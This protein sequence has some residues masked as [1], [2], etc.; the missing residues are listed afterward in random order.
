MNLRPILFSI[1]AIVVQNAFC[2]V[3]LRYGNSLD[4]GWG[5]ANTVVTP[6]VMFPE[7]FVKPY[8]G[9]RVTKVLLGL[10]RKAANGYLYIKQNPED[11]K[12]LYRQ[13]LGD[14][15]EG[16]N[17]ITLDTPY[18]I[19]GNE[20]VTIGY[21][22]LF[23]EAEGVG[24]SREKFADGDKVY[25][26]SEDRWTSTGGSVCIKAIVEGETM[27]ENEMLISRMADMVAP[28]DA[29]TVEYRVVARNAGANAVES[30][31]MAIS[32]NGDSHTILREGK[33]ATNGSDTVTFAVPSVVPGKYTVSACIDKVNGVDDYYSANN[34]T[35]ASL[36]VRDKTFARRVVCEENTGVWC[37]F[38][39]RGIVGLE[40]MKVAYPDR[41][42][43]VCVHSGE[44]PMA[45]SADEDYSYE[46]FIGS[47]GGAPYCNVN[48]RFSGDPYIDINGLYNMEAE[49]EN[50]IAV[51]A[52][53][54]W[55]NDGTISV[56]TTYFTDIDIDEPTFNI[57]Y[58]LTEDGISGYMQTNYYAGGRNGE[59]YGWENKAEV[60]HDVVFDDVA[61]GIFGGYR[62][63]P[64]PDKPIEAGVCY[65]HEYQ[66]QAPPSIADK[67]ALHV[68]AQI[69][70]SK[71]N[72]I[73][74]A[75]RTEIDGDVPDSV[76]ET[77][78]D[79]IRVLSHGGI[80]YVN[81]YGIDGAELRVCDTCGNTL[82]HILLSQDENAIDHGLKGLYIISIEKSDKTKSYKVIL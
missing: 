42:I 68:I 13:K 79:E 76:E 60:T 61:R 80:L 59:M 44:D 63:M 16:W 45:I 56:K 40:L 48:R 51:E 43:A 67:R 19:T 27:P 18:E 36:T 7:E 14:I 8:A 41:F 9:N 78:A 26:N 32:V 55:N 28:Y 52:E 35:S 62:G 15:P 82:R 70:E 53:A 46:E 74:N 29:E 47:C 34:C 37:G 58:T 3:E 11:P 64:L 6:Y 30:Y 20:N 22:A 81:G 2:R 21:K 39:P 72:Q 65:E 73:Y 50:H 33:V 25:Y 31:S 66:I 5:T 10:N 17:E 4:Y 23:G 38:C 24:C 12:Y 71:S 49:A 54:Y 75:V 69:I 1:I 57:A 77:Y